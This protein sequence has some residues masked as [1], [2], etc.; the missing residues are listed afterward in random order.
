MKRLIFACVFTLL[1]VGCGES[2]NS[3]S[4]H[5]QTES[6][7]QHVIDSGVL[8]WGADV[9]GGIPYV[10]E[11][12]D[13]PGEYIGFEVDIAKGIAKHL[14]VKP[15]LVVKAWDSLIPEL[16]KDSF[17]MAMNG[18]EDTS[19]REKSV[20]FSE[21][22][23]FYTQQIT[24]RKSENNIHS[25][26]DLKNKTVGTLSG[27]AAEDILRGV[28]SIQVSINPEIIYSYEDLVEGRI[29][30]VLLDTPIAVAYG[31]SHPELKNVGESFGGGHYVIAFRKDDT[32]F[33]DAIN[34]AIQ[35]MKDNGE[36]KD[37]YKKWGIMNSYQ[38]KL[39]VE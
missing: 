2:N 16:Q 22:Y 26:E 11:D 34:A 31:G 29:D 12:P 24:V 5:S 3:K 4:N 39:G 14:G 6:T 28:P 36:L 37:I 30:A 7:Y 19:D 8:R 20:L 33:R 15:E 38:K 13:N 35:E 23:Y 1:V 9:I 10:Y 17:D 21:P 32:Q 27:T 18:I 25:L